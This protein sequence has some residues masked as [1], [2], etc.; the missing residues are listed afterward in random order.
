MSKSSTYW[1]KSPS[2]NI[3]FLRSLANISPDKVGEFL[4]PWGRTVQQCYWT[5]CASG[6]CHSKANS[7][8]DPSAIG[9]Q[10]KAPFKS[11]TENQLYSP[12]IVVSRVYGLGATGYKFW[13][14]SLTALRSWTKQYSAEFGFLTG[15]IGVL[16]GDLQGIISPVLNNFL[17]IGWIPFWVS[18]L[19]GCCFR[20]GVPTSLFKKLIN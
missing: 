19:R 15:M 3:K 17:R 16:Y 4:N 10:K 14:I 5:T 11:K 20:L 8:C 9:M 18:C 12:R 7:C 1:S 13:T 6:S 2:S